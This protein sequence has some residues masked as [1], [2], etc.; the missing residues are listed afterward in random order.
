MV[1]EAYTHCHP[2]NMTENQISEAR[3]GWWDG[4]NII[5]RDKENLLKPMYP[6]TFRNRVLYENEH[7]TH[8]MRFPES[9]VQGGYLAEAYFKKKWIKV[10]KQNY[11]FFKKF[12]KK[13]KSIPN[14]SFS[15]TYTQNLSKSN[16]NNS[17]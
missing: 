5:V 7:H 3:E 13:K 1:F 9:A 8:S 12:V 6:Q 17:L 11:A 10:L 15:N 2:Q 16:F 14:Y 4:I